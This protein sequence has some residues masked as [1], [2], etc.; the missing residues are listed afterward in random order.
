VT[1]VL[2][3]FSAVPRLAVKEFRYD[4][5]RAR[6]LVRERCPDEGGCDGDVDYMEV[7]SEEWTDYDGE[8]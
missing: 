5:G 8:A 6:Y 7:L 1:D 4:T 3:R 2:T